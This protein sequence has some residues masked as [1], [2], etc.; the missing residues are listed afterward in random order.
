MTTDGG[1]IRI[2]AGTGILITHGVGRRSIMADGIIMLIG[3]GYGVL[4]PIGV[5][6]GFPGDIPLV[7]VAGRRCHRELDL[8][9]AEAGLMAASMWVLIVTLALII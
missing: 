1:F 6:P 5:L 9:L 7:I 8:V 4:T 2:L 3:A